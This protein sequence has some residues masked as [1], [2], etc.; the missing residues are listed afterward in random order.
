MK[1]G[2][3]VKVR[4]TKWMGIGY[5]SQLLLFGMKM[6]RKNRSKISSGHFGQRTWNVRSSGLIIERSEYQ[7]EQL[8]QI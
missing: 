1:K 6:E 4:K 3:V 5:N 8:E 7:Q 2:D